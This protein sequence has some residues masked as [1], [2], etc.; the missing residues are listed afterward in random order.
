MAGGVIPLVEGSE[1]DDVGLEIPGC[2]VTPPGAPLTGAGPA[3]P[4]DTI[5]I[6]KATIEKAIGNFIG[7]RN[8]NVTALKST[9]FAVR[10][11]LATK[12]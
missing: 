2:V 8:Y 5:P 12:C 6:A 4:F 3:K 9:D 10:R 1:V 11:T 7:E